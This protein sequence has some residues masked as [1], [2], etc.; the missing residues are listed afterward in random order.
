LIVFSSRRKSPREM[1]YH[2]VYKDGT[3]V[4]WGKANPN[5]AG[6]RVGPARAYVHEETPLEA[7]V[8]NYNTTMSFFKDIAVWKTFYSITCYSSKIFS[9]HLIASK[10]CLTPLQIIEEFF[11]WFQIVQEYH[12]R[13]QFQE[14]VEIVVATC[15][16]CN[17][18]IVECRILGGEFGC[19]TLKRTLDEFLPLTSCFSRGPAGCLFKSH[20]RVCRFLVFQFLY[21]SHYF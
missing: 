9:F 5:H 19:R 14:V 4:Y 7:F 21:L 3:C 17:N 10:K 12:V 16:V 15:Q 2:V 20:L 11:T 1:E 8:P 6:F 18:R 13:L